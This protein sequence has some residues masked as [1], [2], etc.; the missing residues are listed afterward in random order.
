MRARLLEPVKSIRE[1]REITFEREIPEKN[2][3]EKL[4]VFSSPPVITASK[5]PEPCSRTCARR[6]EI[7]ERAG[8]SDADSPTDRETGLPNSREAASLAKRMNPSR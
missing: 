4:T 8:M 2:S 5:D 3:A 1:T 7:A 6:L